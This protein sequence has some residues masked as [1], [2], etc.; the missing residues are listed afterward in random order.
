VEPIE[1]CAMLFGKIRNEEII[2][3]KIVL[4]TNKLHS[5]KR[6]EIDPEGVAEALM[7][8]DRE[9]LE[10]V[11]LFHSHPAPASPSPLDV[12]FMRLWG[13]SIWL[14]LS[15]TEGQIGAYKMENGKVVSVTI[16]SPKTKS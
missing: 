4:A 10:F 9:G 6:F 12:K 15:L 16:N 11:G 2:V 8:A 7:E 13:D 5:E 14:I 3:K 1:A